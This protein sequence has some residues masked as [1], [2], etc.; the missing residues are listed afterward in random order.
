[1]YSVG[2]IRPH[3]QCWLKMH[4]KIHKHAL[5]GIFSLSHVTGFS[6]PRS[7]NLK[8]FNLY[9]I[10]DWVRTGDIEPDLWFLH[11]ALEQAGMMLKVSSCWSQT[12]HGFCDE[13]DATWEEA[14]VVMNFHGLV[15]LTGRLQLVVVLALGV[16]SSL[17]WECGDDLSRT[18]FSLY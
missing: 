16:N 7:K 18:N 9:N 12:H 11:R 5:A 4:S 15:V 1:M 13:V 8:H 2:W 10:T 17:M 6:M 14:A 3:P